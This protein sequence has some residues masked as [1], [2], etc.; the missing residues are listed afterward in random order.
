MLAFEWFPKLDSAHVLSHT[1]P[2]I[3][4]AFFPPSSL[5]PPS[6]SPQAVTQR[7]LQTLCTCRLSSTPHPRGA[8]GRLPRVAG[9]GHQP[10]VSAWITDFLMP[11]IK[12]AAGSCL[13]DTHA[14]LCVIGSSRWGPPA[15]CLG[16]GR[17]QR[18]WG[19]GMWRALALS[20][21]QFF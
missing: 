14:V 10:Q 2:P 4:P 1:L 21:F 8:L 13:F 9:L 16:P 18:S 12:A 11:E 17:G 7:V 5:S 19:R 3:F 20:V 15:D 6:S